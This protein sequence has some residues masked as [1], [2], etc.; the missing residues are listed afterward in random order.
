MVPQFYQTEVNNEH[1]IRGNAAILKCVIPSFVADFVNVAGWVSDDGNT[2]LPSRHD[3]HGNCRHTPPLLPHTS[4]FLLQVYSQLHLL[5]RRQQ[6]RASCPSYS[7]C[8][9]LQDL[10]VLAVN[11]YFT[12][13]TEVTVRSST[14]ERQR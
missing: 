11:K 10:R 12:H 8:L 6:V 7:P 1:V 13:T 3:A 14:A 2:Y 4:P 5:Y 9:L